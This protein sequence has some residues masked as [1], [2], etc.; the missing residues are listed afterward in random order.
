VIGIL[1]LNGRS[2]ARPKQHDLARPALK[3][4]AGLAL[5]WKLAGAPRAPRGRPKGFAYWATA[6]EPELFVYGSYGE[7]AWLWGMVRQGQRVPAKLKVAGEGCARG[8]WYETPSEAY[9]CNSHGFTIT[10]D[11]TKVEG[12]R[13]PRLEQALPYTYL[14]ATEK[15]TL[16]FERVPTEKQ[17]QAAAEALD[18]KS[19][20][21]EV[22]DAALEGA[23]FAALDRTV[24]GQSGRFYR[25]IAGHY[26]RADDMER[27]TASSMR[28]EL[29]TG[30]L[31]LPLAF[32][33]SD[34]TPVHCLKAKKLRP[35]GVAAKHARFHVVRELERDGRRYVQGPGSIIVAR[36]AVRVASRCKRPSGVAKDEKWIHFDLAQQALVAYEGDRPVFATLFSSGKEGHDTPAGLYRIYL[37]QISARM[38]GDDPKD[39]PYDIGEVPWVMYY[40]D[41]YAVHGAYWHDV[42]GQVRSHGCTNL[43]PADARWVFFWSEPTVPRGWHGM[44][45][46]EGTVFYFAR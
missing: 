24:Q 11:P 40:K 38:S 34:R 37:K 26:V 30:K 14:K 33:L 7:K 32:V 41:S 28:G 25:T 39:G 8:N 23:Y 5:S 17:Q 9:L 21:P 44:H 22:V 3:G 1:S 4:W 6:R 36:D 45:V 46:R 27:V 16:R 29:V 18:S 10:R 15:P 31:K 13:P 43:A 35:C 12:P 42:F 2:G 19:E 20:L